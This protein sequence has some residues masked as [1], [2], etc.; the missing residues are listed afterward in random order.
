MV[1]Q[2]MESQCMP[3][4]PERQFC[5]EFVQG[6]ELS[7][8]SENTLQLFFQTEETVGPS[9]YTLTQHVQRIQCPLFI[10]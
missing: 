10:V 7:S 6:M 4:T 8:G 2:Y 5:S 1:S 3:T 9:P